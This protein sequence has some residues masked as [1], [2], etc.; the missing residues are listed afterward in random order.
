[1][2]DK[3]H[4]ESAPTKVAESGGRLRAYNSPRLTVRYC[5]AFDVASCA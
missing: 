3:L 4:H 5:H 2:V 1:M